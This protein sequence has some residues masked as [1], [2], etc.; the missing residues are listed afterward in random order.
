LNI[1][2]VDSFVG[3]VV[4]TGAAGRPGQ[5]VDRPFDDLLSRPTQI[6]RGVSVPIVVWSPV[7]VSPG[8][9]D[10]WIGYPPHPAGRRPRRMTELSIVSKWGECMAPVCHREDLSASRPES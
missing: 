5:A 8:A 2:G 3:L 1:D 10:G 4:H 6:E 7:P 9:R